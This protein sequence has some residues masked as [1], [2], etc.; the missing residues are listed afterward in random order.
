MSHDSH[1]PYEI[2]LVKA[3]DGCL[4][5]RERQALDEHLATC[6]ECRA[7]LA[8]F[9]RVKEVTDAMTTRILADAAIEPP[10]ESAA[11]KVWLG[12][13]LGLVGLGVGV[14]LGFGAWELWADPEVP[15]ILKVALGACALGLGGVGAY[16]LTVRFAGRSRDPYE[17]I[18]Q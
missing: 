1:E 18:D 4:T 7:E 17:E 14:L 2:L 13:S 12:L 16:L 11:T 3:T 10:R 9:R 5:P 6:A 8:D 15:L